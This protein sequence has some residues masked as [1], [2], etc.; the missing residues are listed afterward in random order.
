M[1]VDTKNRKNARR[2]FEQIYGKQAL[3]DQ[4]YQIISQG[5][6]GL[7]AFILELGRTMAE[8]VMYMERENMAGPDYYPKDSKIHKW[9]SQRGS[10]YIGDQKVKLEHPRLRGPEGEINLESYQKLREPEGFSEELLSKILRGISCQKY[11][12]TVT[13]TAGAFGVSA[14]SV[15]KHIIAATAK[16]LSEFKERDLSEFKP[17]AIFLDSVHRAGAAFLVCLGINLSGEK[18]VLGFWE[19]ATENNEICKE[20]FSDLERRGLKV[21][22]RIIWVTDG[23]SGIIKALKDKFGKHL[24][25]QRCT[26]HKDRNIQ[27]HLPKKYRKQAHRK[28]TI[29]LEQTKYNDARQ[30]LMEFEKWLRQIN[31]SAADSLLE[32]IEEILTLHRLEV[33]A[34]LRKTLHSTNPIE[35]MFSTVRDCEGNIKRYRGTSMAQRWLATVCLHCEKGFRKIKGYR[36]IESVIKKVAA[37]QT[38]E[39]QLSDAA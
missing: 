22:K 38:E 21:S 10:V 1:K 31:E 6:Q 34:L 2:G 26:I 37:L 33:P 19:G 4:M 35:S 32:A 8:T 14:G 15:S 18:Q 28:Y 27:R 3:I 17:F 39:H 16:K 20:L 5:K 30:M 12:E 36:Q 7:D 23:G 25:H 29:A 24:I 13:E 11:S 9:A